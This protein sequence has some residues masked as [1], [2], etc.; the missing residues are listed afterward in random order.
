[1]TTRIGAGSLASSDED[2]YDMHFSARILSVADPYGYR[3]ATGEMPSSCWKSSLSAGATAE[4]L[5]NTY[6]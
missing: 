1:M 4:D 2:G 3:P 6:A 5:Q